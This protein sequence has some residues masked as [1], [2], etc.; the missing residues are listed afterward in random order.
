[1]P[2][3]ASGAGNGIWE[4]D[5]EWELEWDLGM[6]PG[7]LECGCS[8]SELDGSPSGVHCPPLLV[9]DEGCG[10]RGE[11]GPTRERVWTL[12]LRPIHYTQVIKHSLLFSGLESRELVMKREER[13]YT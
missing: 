7:Y 4:W 1:M 3:Y 10:L 9:Q 6:G 11:L 8:E 2:V 5:L 13:L 12:L